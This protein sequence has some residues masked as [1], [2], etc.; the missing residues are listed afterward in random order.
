[1]QGAQLS[2]E[3]AEVN[4][5]RASIQQADSKSISPVFLITKC[6]N[7]H[8]TNQML[9]LGVHCKGTAC[10]QSTSCTDTY[11]LL[12]ILRCLVLHESMQLFSRESLLVH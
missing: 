6:H 7:L 12:S 1:M 9:E 8:E 4:G 10:K 11:C 3:T 2:K 5:Y